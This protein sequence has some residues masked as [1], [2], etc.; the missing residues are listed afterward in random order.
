MGRRG[1]WWAAVTGF[2]KSWTWL[3]E[4]LASYREEENPQRCVS[5]SYAWSLHSLGGKPVAHRSLWITHFEDPWSHT[6]KDPWSCGG[7]FR[8]LRRLEAPWRFPAES[9]YVQLQPH[10]RAKHLPFHQANAQHRASK[11]FPGLV[12]F[13]NHWLRV[14]FV[15]FLWVWHSTISHHL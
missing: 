10:F 8:T 11:H 4:A 14:T 1:A 6:A 2:A 5:C 7:G 13:E 9:R 3:R 15:Y 12:Q